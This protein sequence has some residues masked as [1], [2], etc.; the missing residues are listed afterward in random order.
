MRAIAGTAPPTI[1]YSPIPPLPAVSQFPQLQEH[2][3]WGG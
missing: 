1:R 3:S 2:G